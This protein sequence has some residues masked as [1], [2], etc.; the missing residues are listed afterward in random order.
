ME[1]QVDYKNGDKAYISDVVSFYHSNVVEL[2]AVLEVV[3]AT[4]DGKGKTLSFTFENIDAF[5]VVDYKS[6]RNKMW[7]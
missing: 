2:G 6:K 4:S 7:F 5:H 3:K 1:V